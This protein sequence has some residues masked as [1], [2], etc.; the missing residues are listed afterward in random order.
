MMD[1]SSRRWSKWRFSG[2]D[3]NCVE[4][5]V[6]TDLVGVRDSKS[7]VGGLLMLPRQV[8]RPFLVNVTT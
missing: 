4:V 5:A 3:E 6:D 7:P 1:L 8:W 2:P